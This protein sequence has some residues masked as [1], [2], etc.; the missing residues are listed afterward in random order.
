MTA[1]EMP[2][3]G[4]TALRVVIADD[5]ALFRSGL[6]LM[7]DAQQDLTVVAE[8]A[9][10]REA[11]DTAQ[12]ERPDVV[13]MDIQMPLLDGIA[14][15]AELRRRGLHAKV[16]ILTT[17]DLDRY[18]YDALRA[19]ASGFLLKSARPAR[20]ID[21]IRA[22]AAGDALLD[23]ALTRRLI[24]KWMAHPRADAADQR[25]A[26]LT[27]REREVLTLIG[28]GLSNTEIAALLHL[29]ESTVKTHVGRTLAKTGSRDRVQAVILAF[30]C[31]LVTPGQQ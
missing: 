26:T 20:L 6:R 7:V 10:G 15:T 22:V 1:G 24:E 31:G 18:V 3:T 16:L 30:E 27:D 14:A 4:A 23:T 11:V 28:R 19:G 12:R 9:N 8:V 13:L 5:E 25:L 17:F 21:A 29:G 2:A